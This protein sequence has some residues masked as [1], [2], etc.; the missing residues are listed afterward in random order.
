MAP[1][2]KTAADVPIQKLAV[3]YQ[4]VSTKLQAIDARSGIDRQEQALQHFFILL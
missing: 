3:S 4:R 1:T 2:T